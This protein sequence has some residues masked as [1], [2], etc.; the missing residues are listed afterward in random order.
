MPNTT[1][2]FSMQSEKINV[3]DIII[4]IFTYINMTIKKI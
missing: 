3:M 4:H 2:V 1:T